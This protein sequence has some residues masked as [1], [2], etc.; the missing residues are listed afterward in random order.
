MLVR[1]KINRVYI[2][3]RFSRRRWLRLRYSYCGGMC[4]RDPHRLAV[5]TRTLAKFVSVSRT[6]EENLLS[7]S[8]LQRSEQNCK[9]ICELAMQSKDAHLLISNGC[10]H[11][12]RTYLKQTTRCPLPR[13]H[14][15]SIL[16]E[17]SG[18]VDVCESLFNILKMT[19]SFFLKEN[20]AS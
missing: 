20:L 4:D 17:E 8:I 1:R 15:D 6:I 16:R 2:K 3:F 9:E 14:I 12:L 11:T 18:Y 19:L 5:L 7:H 13:R 10:R